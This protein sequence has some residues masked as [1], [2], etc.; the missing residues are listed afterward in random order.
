LLRL[1]PQCSSQ[2]TP[3]PWWFSAPSLLWPMT[4]SV[5]SLH[6]TMF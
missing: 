2:T 4:S 3:F 1:W 6:S 5:V